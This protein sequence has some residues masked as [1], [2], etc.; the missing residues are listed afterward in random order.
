MRFI[1][2]PNWGYWMIYDTK[3]NSNVVGYSKKLFADITSM[4]LNNISIEKEIEEMKQT[5]KSVDGYGHFIRIH[6]FAK[7]HT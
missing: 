7:I 6:H 5:L 3:L 1:V 2:K 4:G